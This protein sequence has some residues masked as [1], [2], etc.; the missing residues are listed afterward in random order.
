MKKLTLLLSCLI[1]LFAC[2]QKSDST[3][4]EYK[5]IRGGFIEHSTELKSKRY[6]KNGLSEIKGG[7][8][9]VA[10][11]A[12]KDGERTGRW[13]FFKFA[14]SAIVD[15]I[16]NYTTNEVE[17]NNAPENAS[18]EIEGFETSKN[19]T[20][21]CKIG[22]FDYGMHFLKREFKIPGELKSLKGR[23]DVFLIFTIDSAGKL[24]NYEQKIASTSYNS[25]K[26]VDLAKFKPTDLTFISAKVNGVAVKSKLILKESVTIN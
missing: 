4:T 1:P 22:G 26:T 7:R 21:P 24:I 13:Y 12:Y 2:A 14:D 3:S 23:H 18:Y 10:S 11:G 17:I 25:S 5:I 9:K 16:Y 20:Y 15:Q 8:K 6:I 19:V